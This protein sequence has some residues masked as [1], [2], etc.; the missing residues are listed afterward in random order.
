MV[1]HAHVEMIKI[2]SL[3]WIAVVSIL[4]AILILSSSS[5]SLHAADPTATSTESAPLLDTVPIAYGE[6]R[7]GVL[8]PP[9]PALFYSF[10]AAQGDIVTIR[11]T[12]TGGLL[13][14]F[15]ILLDSGAANVIAVNDDQSPS[16]TSAMIRLV[17]TA[18]GEYV[19]KCSDSPRSDIFHDGVFRLEM[20][21]EN[22]TP[23]PSAL[24]YD[25]MVAPLTFGGDRPIRSE[26]NA[27][28]P[29]RLYTF[30]GS[31]TAILSAQI[32]TTGDLQAA[33]Y[34]YDYRFDKRHAAA[35]LGS[36]LQTRLPERTRYY[37]A[38]AR[39]GGSG[40]FTIDATLDW[41]EAGDPGSAGVGTPQQAL[42]PGQSITVALSERVAAVYTLNVNAQMRLRVNVLSADLTDLPFVLVCDPQDQQLT[43]A[44][45]STAEIELSTPGVHTVILIRGRGIVAPSSATYTITLDGVITAAFIPTFTP[46]VTVVPRR[47]ED[48]N[49]GATVTPSPPRLIRYDDILTDSITDQTSLRYYVFNGTQGDRVT[50]RMAAIN[51]T[52]DPVLYLYAISAD[53]TTVLAGDDNGG[54]GLD[55]AIADFVL[56]QTGSYLLVA[57][58]SADEPGSIGEFTLRLSRSVG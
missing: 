16:D 50:I 33:L 17:I 48:V 30:G 38:V 47:T 14:P 25:P 31:D 1:S 20:Q 18:S 13:N 28:T 27:D 22:P 44:R 11:M 9:V 51:G 49:S 21:L 23:T 43:F 6:T 54:G 4:L 19:I 42:V 58:R 26:L 7:D 52:L 53:G 5:S 45:G 15:L 55:A 2:A 32:R 12:T 24:R 3:K 36:T 34:L 57:S 39:L 29:T 35:E 37:L 41:G 46:S 40:T 56:P 10:R 8:T